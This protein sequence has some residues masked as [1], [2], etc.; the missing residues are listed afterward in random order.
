M[1]LSAFLFFGGTKAEKFSIGG[2]PVKDITRVT[3]SRRGWFGIN[4]SCQGSIRSE[5]DI[6]ASLHSSLSGIRVLRE[7]ENESRLSSFDR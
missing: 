3:S 5:E 7:F 4:T 1:F 2:L 6:S